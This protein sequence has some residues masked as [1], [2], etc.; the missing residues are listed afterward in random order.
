M[1]SSTPSSGGGEN[2]SDEDDIACIT[3][4]T[5]IEKAD[6]S[7][8]NVNNNKGNDHNSF[9]LDSVKN[10]LWISLILLP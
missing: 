8:Q 10:P 3:A 1:A 4:K 2:L 7:Q 5:Q 9:D 6:N